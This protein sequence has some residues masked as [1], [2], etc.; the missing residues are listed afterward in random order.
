[1]LTMIVASLCLVLLIKASA[2][3]SIR[4]HAFAALDIADLVPL[5]H[6]MTRGP[7]FHGQAHHCW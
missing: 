2:S 5:C 1:M 4:I 6:C 3:R 7:G